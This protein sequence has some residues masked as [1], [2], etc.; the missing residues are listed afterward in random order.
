MNI[1]KTGD[2]RFIEVQGTA[3]AEPFGREALMTLLDLADLGIT[4][5]VEKQRAL[6]GHL[7]KT[8]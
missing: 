7:V 1:V 5:L 8:Q 6:V 2:G 4:Q 3:E